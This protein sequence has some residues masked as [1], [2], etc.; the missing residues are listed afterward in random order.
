MGKKKELSESRRISKMMKYGGLG[1]LKWFCDVCKFQARSAEAFKAHTQSEHHRLMMSQ[2]RQDQNSII[3]SNS[4]EFKRQFLNILKRKYANREVLANIV[5]VQ[6]IS[7]KNHQHMNSTRWE[8]V[9]GF[10]SEMAQKG[11]IEMRMT[12]RGPFIKYVEK[13]PVSEA[14]AK[15]TK[16]IEEQF[17]NDLKV[18]EKIA[19]EM[20]KTMPEMRFDDVVKEEQ[21]VDVQI[22]KEEKPVMKKVSSLFGGSTKPKPPPKKEIK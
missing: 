5:Y 2:F 14:A 12:E 20:M 10:C 7:D 22:I 4:E 11:I 3:Q 17:Q 19:E 9:R 21:S 8:S 15:L 18:E 16:E 13:D 6:V 1:K